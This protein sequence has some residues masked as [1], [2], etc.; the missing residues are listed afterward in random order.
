MKTRSEGRKGSLKVA[1]RSEDYG[2]SSIEDAVAAI[3]SGK[4]IIVVDDED[5]ENEG[6]LTIAADKITAEAINFMARYGRG[7]ICMPMTSERLDELDIPLMVSHNTARFDTAFCVSIEAKESTSTGISADD[8]AAT[9]RAAMDSETR[10]ADLARPG[11]MFPLRARP[12][13]VLVRAGQTEAAVDL[14]RIAGLNPAGVICEIMNDDGTMSRVP[15]LAEF[16]GLHNLPMITIAE[17][18]KYRMG[19][20]RL[21]RRLASA[22]LPTDFGEFHVVA[23]KNV[24]GDETHVAMVRGEIGD[25]QGVVVRVHSRCLTG[26][27]FHSTRCL[28]GRQLQASLSRVAQEPRAVLLYLNQDSQGM[29]LANQ[30]LAY[31][32]QDQGLDSVEANERVGVT[33]DQRDYGIGAQILRDL[34]VRSMRILTNNPRKFV[35]LEGYGLSIVESIPFAVGSTTDSAVNLGSG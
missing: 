14:A 22:K 20:E 21:V 33:P 9:V 24:I 18:I 12:G 28:C 23:Y 25:G 13:G 19:T 26:D 1:H 8:R 27:V 17:L 35:G 31:E 6:D 4:M 2:F 7:L 10:P 15:E 29:T 32:L 3:R 16:A 34:G 30:I 11:H 5:R